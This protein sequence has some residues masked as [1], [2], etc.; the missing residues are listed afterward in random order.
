MD[1]DNLWSSDS[2]E[3]FSNAPGG[4]FDPKGSLFAAAGGN[5]FM[6]RSNMTGSMTGFNAAHFQPGDSKQVKEL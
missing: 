5:N 2:V 4:P 1:A 3:T 6:T